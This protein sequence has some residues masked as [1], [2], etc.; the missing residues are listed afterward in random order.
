MSKQVIICEKPSQA[1]DV[2]AGLAGTPFAKAEVLA[3]QGH[4]IKLAEPHEVNPAWER[5]STEVLLPPQGRYPLK[6]DTGSG[7]PERLKQIREALKDASE[8]IIATDCDREGE[9]IGREIVEFLGF[10]GPVKRALFTAQDKKTIQ[11]SFS[12]LKPASELEGVYQAF[13]A[14]QQA[15]QVYNLSLTRAASVLLPHEK[16]KAIG[17]GR[18]KTPTMAIVCMRE[19]E[20]QRF[21]VRDYYEVSATAKVAAG[22][23]QMRHVGKDRIEDKAKAEAIAKAAEGFSGP[24]KVKVSDERQAP[25]KLF[26]LPALQKACSARFGW[27]AAKTL[28]VAQELYEAH[29]ITYPRA[30]SRY[31]SESMIPQAAE[32]M[33]Q[34][35]RLYGVETPDEPVIRKG[36]DGVFSDRALEGVS[37]HAVIPNVNGDLTTIPGLGGDPRRLFDL[38]A[39]AYLS[40]LLPDHLYRQTVATLDVQGH[41]FRATGRITTSPGWKAVYEEVTEDDA[42]DDGEQSLPAMSDGESAALSQAKVEAKKTKPPPRYT[43]GSLIA[44]M[45]DAWKFLPADRADLRERLKEA[46]GLGT[47]ATRAEVIKGLKDQGFLVAKGKNVVPSEA[48]LELYRLLAESAPRLVDPGVT[49]LWETALDEVVL[50]KRPALQ[51]VKSVADDAAK[52]IDV[53]KSKAPERPAGGADGAPSEKKLAFARRLADEKGVPLPKGAETDWKVCSAFIDE[54]LKATGG[55]L[56]P[57]EKQLGFARKL[58]AEKGIPL[59][60]AATT[61]A[62]SCSAFIDRCLASGGKGGGSRFGNR[63]A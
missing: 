53:L 17:I 41:E 34:L 38:V 13:I 32:L 21:Q 27:T 36:K 52:I 14:R 29:V 57:S 44:A 15:D 18:V 12:K 43:E 47:P 49:A 40:A 35:A 54:C 5:W 8:V 30:E 59:P 33:P 48:A 60:D 11:A 9:G 3:A 10:K 31:L 63:A 37:H 6:A 2:R 25:P 62:K 46:K 55:K 4:I 42:A 56:P 39:R 51:V 24:L 50:G 28:E 19:L 1:K 7:K 61:D 20:I 45:Q 26:D 23:F 22:G 16:G 58:S